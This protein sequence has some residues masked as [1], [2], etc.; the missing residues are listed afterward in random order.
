MTWLR[1]TKRCS[2]PVDDP[3]CPLETA[4]LSAA[5]TVALVVDPTEPLAPIH[6]VP[7]DDAVRPERLPDRMGTMNVGW[8]ESSWRSPVVISGESAVV[9]IPQAPTQTLPTIDW[10]EVARMA[11]AELLPNA[12][13]AS[14][15]TELAHRILDPPVAA[16]RRHD[17]ALRSLLR[18]H[19]LLRWS[20][21][22]LVL[23]SVGLA[24]LKEPLIPR[25]LPSW[26]LL[27][28]QA[29]L[30]QRRLDG[31]VARSVL[32]ADA[33]PWCPTARWLSGGR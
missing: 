20:A 21:R 13:D 29:R 14:I 3:G 8:G 2:V 10:Y 5:R 7:V 4:A 24:A 11:M 23:Q 22:R 30:P 32:K 17:H 6:A 15:R 33:R 28:R 19:R 16:L 26:R 18:A 25:D 12:V 27:A 9:E 1:P 31:A